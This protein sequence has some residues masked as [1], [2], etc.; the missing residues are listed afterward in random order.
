MR[1]YWYKDNSVSIT[2]EAYIDSI[3]ERFNMGAC[4]PWS[5]PMK[6]STNTNHNSKQRKDVERYVE[7]VGC[8]MWLYITTRLDLGFAATFN[9]RF[10]ARATTVNY[11]RALGALRYLKAT[12]IRGLYYTPLGC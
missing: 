2:Q 5:V 8:L 9:A 10:T 4:R 1:V 7:L 12:R 3:L 11:H 6:A